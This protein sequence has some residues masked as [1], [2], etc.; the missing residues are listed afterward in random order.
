[1]ESLKNMEFLRDIA[2]VYAPF[3]A[4]V[5]VTLTYIPQI[6]KTHKKKSVEDMSILF[7]IL[8][9]FFLVCMWFNSLFSMIDHNNVGYFITESIN[10]G[11][12]L[13][14]FFQ[15]IYYKKRKRS[16]EYATLVSSSN[17]F[18]RK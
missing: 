6:V 13:V 8:L 5:F 11:L 18:S 7:W 12:A 15:I 3:M 2:Y 14:V 16:V 1:M 17:A 10:F 4:S 9:N